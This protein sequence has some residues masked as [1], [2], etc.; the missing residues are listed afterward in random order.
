ML[1]DKFQKFEDLA[2]GE[3]KKKEK[4]REEAERKRK[5]RIARKQKE[6]EAKTPVDTDDR[7]TEL[8]DEEAAKLQQEIEE[9]H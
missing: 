9:V 7:V 8:T 3:R 5:E 6:E 2:L 4:E 1:L